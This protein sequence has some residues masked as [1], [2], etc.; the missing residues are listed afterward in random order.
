MFGT[1]IMKS[2]KKNTFF[3]FLLSFSNILF[4]LIT[5][6]YISRILLINDI[7]VLNKGTSIYTL[8][9][10]LASFGL[11]GY[12]AREIARHKNEQDVMQKTFSSVLASHLFTVF[13][14]SLIYFCYIFFFTAS[15]QKIVNILYILLFVITP[16]SVEWFYIGRE[17]FGYIALRSF[18]IKVLLLI[19]VFTLVHSTEDFIYYAIIFIAAQGINFLYNIFHARLF[20]HFSFKCVNIW[21]TFSLSKFFY[22]Q[23]LVAICYQNI[24]QLILGQ[25]EVQLALFVRALSFATLISALITPICNAVKPRLEYVIS[26]DVERYK[27]Y[28]NNAFDCIMSILCPVVLGMVALSSNITLIF[29]GKQFEAGTSVLAVCCLSSFSTQ[30]A[31]FLNTIISTPAG[32]EK[33]TFFSNATVAACALILNPILI[34]K[35]GALGASFAL[36]CAETFGVIVHLLLIKRHKLYSDWLDIKKTKYLFSAVLMFFIV[37]YVKQFIANIY[38][39]CFI[40]VCFG[41][42]AYIFFVLIFSKL[43]KDSW[44]YIVKNVLARLRKNI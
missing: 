20:V 28:I 8:F 7:G 23:T 33:N 3:N 40:G 30:I 6:P 25:N 16:L 9:V 22:F 37:V 36:L 31:V 26:N 18:S 1:E 10:N 17:D 19:L 2:V 41:V 13:I 32:F 43:F 42:F 44:P 4:P 11:S 24:N 15:E 5:M 29:G 38:M 21:K 35:F 27:S 34:S 12:G 39:Q 14:F